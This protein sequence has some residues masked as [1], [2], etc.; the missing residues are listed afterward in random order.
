MASLWIDPLPL[1]D[2]PPVVAPPRR[3]VDGRQRAAAVSVRR[4]PAV[5]RPLPWHFYRRRAVAV[6]V[7]VVGLL[8]AWQSVSALGA[9][10]VYSPATQLGG[11]PDVAYVVHDAQP[12]DTLWSLAATLGPDEDVRASLD[13]LTRLNGGS[14]LVVGQQVR[15]PRSWYEGA[16]R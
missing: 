3:S 16:G 12:G 5:R 4:P 10:L 13:E 7:L 1:P 6:A 14:G 8:L 9:R 2:V 15:V 11:A